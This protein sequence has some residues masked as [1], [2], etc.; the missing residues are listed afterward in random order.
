MMVNPVLSPCFL[1]VVGPNHPKKK[2]AL[3]VLP[4]LANE[5][6]LPTWT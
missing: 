5:L 3:D 1:E 4:T 6:V 2:K